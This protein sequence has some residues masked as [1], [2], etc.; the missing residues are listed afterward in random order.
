MDKRELI[1]MMNEAGYTFKRLKNKKR[2]SDKPKVILYTASV[3]YMLVWVLVLLGGFVNGIEIPYELMQ[4]LIQW[5]S[6]VYGIIFGGYC[7]Q[8]AYEYKV[9]KEC[10]LLEGAGGI[11]D[12]RKKVC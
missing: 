5:S 3:F 12:E 9:D 11:Y 7:G 6:I 1:D 2:K 4:N 10:E 8:S